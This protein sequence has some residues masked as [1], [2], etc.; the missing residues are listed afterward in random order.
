[1]TP[2]WYPDYV[3]RGNTPTAVVVKEKM[4]VTSGEIERTNRTGSEV[5]DLQ[6]ER[7]A[8]MNLKNVHKDPNA[9]LVRQT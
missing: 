8:R 9:L 4:E 6:T 2:R 7:A 3:D 5:D 1:V